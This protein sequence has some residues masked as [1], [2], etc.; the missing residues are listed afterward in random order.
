MLLKKLS[1]A[2]ASVAL[3]FAAVAALETAPANAVQLK[4]FN[5]FGTFASQTQSGS[6]GRAANLV[7]GSFDG[8]YTID[9]DQ[10]PA[11][12]EGTLLRSWNVN[13]RSAANTTLTTLSNLLPGSL[14][15]I[16][17]N[18]ILP[19]DN[20]IFNGNDTSGG[21]LA[22]SFNSGFTGTGTAVPFDNDNGQ[23]VVGLLAIDSDLISVTSTSSTP[24]PEPITMSGMI[25]GSAIGLVMKLKQK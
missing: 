18:S 11:N 19:G 12:S 24:V 1:Q 2:T 10:L 22:L 6:G 21:F 20:L 23:P 9:V 13:L 15:T 4:T 17:S 8:T 7:N 5:L 16:A 25:L 14:A 3:G